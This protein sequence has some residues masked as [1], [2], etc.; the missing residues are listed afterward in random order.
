MGLDKPEATGH[1][2]EHGV[3]RGKGEL[4]VTL[5]EGSGM[6]GVV[7]VGQIERHVAAATVA[8]DGSMT[9]TGGSLARTRRLS[10]SREG[11]TALG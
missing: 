7:G 5:G 4:T 3:V 8:G 1:E 2:K 11:G 6:P 9:T 10:Q